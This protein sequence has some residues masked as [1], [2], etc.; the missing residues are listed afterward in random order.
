[1]K[2]DMGGSPPTGYFESES[3][4]TGWAK[5]GV[6]TVKTHLPRLLESERSYLG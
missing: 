1:M 5:K 4:I 3:R 6:L 2:K